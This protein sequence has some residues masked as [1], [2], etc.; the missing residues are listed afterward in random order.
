MTANDNPPYNPNQD[1]RNGMG[2]YVRTP[3]KAAEDAAIADH[4]AQGS[5]S[6]TET[7][8][9]FGISKWAAMSAVRRA[10]R[11]VVQEAG[12]EALRV[13]L[14][15]MEYLFAKATEVIEADHVIVSHGRIVVGD[16]GN[17]LRDHAPVIAAINSARQCLESV[18]SLTGMKKPAKVEHSG[19]V[20]Y[21]LVGVDPQDLA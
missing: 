7:A 18:Q 13:H 3:E 14:D 17:P 10:V 2:R 11:E 20:T 21:Q 5:H 16:D 19:G 9:H 4:W 12:E 15:R 8:K 1:A 6:Y